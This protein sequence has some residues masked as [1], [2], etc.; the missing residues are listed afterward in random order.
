MRNFF[1]TSVLYIITFPAVSQV[2]DSLTAKEYANAESFLRYTTQQYV[3]NAKVNANWISNDKFWYRNLTG[4]GSEFILINASKGARAAAFDQQKIANALNT[5]TSSNYKASMLPFQTFTYA[6]DEKSISFKIKDKQWK[7]DLETYTLTAD[8]DSGSSSRHQQ[9]S[10]EVLSPD[11][12]KAV[13][14]KDYNLWIRDVATKEF[15]F[16]I[17]AIVRVLR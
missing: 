13:F 12:S 17:I 11:R 6:T 1:I 15:N 10:N 2:K 4:Q 5:A 16:H 8:E 9:K 14:I 3:D 7:A